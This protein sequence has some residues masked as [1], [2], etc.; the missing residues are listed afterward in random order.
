MLKYLNFK[1]DFINHKEQLKGILALIVYL[2]Y[3][4]L[5]VIPFNIIN[6]DTSKLSNTFIT[7][8][9]VGAEIFVIL[10]IILLFKKELIKQFNDFKKN[11]K[12]YFDKYFK[13]WFLLLI[14]TMISNAIIMALNSGEIANNEE[15]LNKLFTNNPIYVY[16]LS[17]LIAPVIEELVFRHSIRKIFKN[18]WLFIIISGLF[19]GFMHV[20]GQADKLSEYLYIITYSIPGFIFAYIYAKSKNIYNPISLHMFHN[21]IMICLQFL[22]LMF[23]QN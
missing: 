16:F 9:T 15:A 3:P 13:F 1:Q 21:G 18:D 20:L 19:F 6:Y 11:K 14:L 22:L 7:L 5:I 2:C 17:V 12:K 8:Y 4:Y 10:L 23:G